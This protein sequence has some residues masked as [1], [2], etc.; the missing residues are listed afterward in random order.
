MLLK[1]VKISFRNDQT[2]VKPLR[3]FR[4]SELAE[5]LM[6]GAQGRDVPLGGEGSPW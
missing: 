5:T 3:Q 4:T 2:G 6:F 1:L